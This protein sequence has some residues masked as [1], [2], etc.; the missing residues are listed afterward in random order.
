[1]NH[2]RKIVF[3]DIDGTIYES[4]KGTPESTKEA[5]QLLKANGHIPVM[6]TG[7]PMSSLFPEQLELGFPCIIGGAGAYIAYE[8]KVLRDIL[9]DPRLV[10]RTVPK[11]EAIGCTVILEGPKYLSYRYEGKGREYF[12][13]LSFLHENY[14]DRIK[15]MEPER[16]EASKMTFWIPDLE[17]FEALKPEL[18]R[19]FALAQYES[20]PCT[21]MM[22]AGITKADGIRALIEYLGIPRENTY[23]FGDG[24][25][26]LEMLQYVQYGT[27]MGN[28]EESVLKTAKYRTESIWEDGVYLALKRYGLI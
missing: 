21:E 26:D 11:L 18:S 8:G 1:M 16:D 12:R 20:A 13:I 23:A 7:R 22:P 14:P 3:F 4:G 2:D 17:A 15:E 25:N 10:A 19:D 6:C 27:A 5:L 9:L 24:P 28:A